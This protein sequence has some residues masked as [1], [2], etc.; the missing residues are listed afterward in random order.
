MKKRDFDI[1][2]GVI[3]SRAQVGY[4]SLSENRFKLPFHSTLNIRLPWPYRSIARLIGRTDSGRQSKF[5]R[6]SYREKE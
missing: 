6:N 2:Q 5:I 1:A 4:I 3:A